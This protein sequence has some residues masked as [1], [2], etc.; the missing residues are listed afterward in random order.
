MSKLQVVGVSDTHGEFP[1]VPDG[2]LLVHAG[3]F[4]NHSTEQEFFEFNKW[5]GVISKKFTYKPIVVFGNHETHAEKI[6]MEETKELLSNCTI[7]FDD[8]I[9]VKGKRIYGTPWVPRYGDWSF[10]MLD[11]ALSN[12]YNLIPEGLDLLITHGPP[13]RILDQNRRNNRCGSEALRQRLLEMKKPPRFHVFGHI[14]TTGDQPRQELWNGINCFNLSI[15]DDWYNPT[16]E[17]TV[18]VI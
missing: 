3:D 10:M 12:K 4:S 14:H 1:D 13:R 8:E 15:M 16:N 7:L 17:P 2:D 9:I 5:L 18:M 11:A 6:G